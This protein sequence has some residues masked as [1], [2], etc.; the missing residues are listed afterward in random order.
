MVSSADYPQTPAK[1]LSAA[2][3]AVR[4]ALYTAL[5]AAVAGLERL[6]PTPLPWIRLGLA[7]G[8][9]LL[10]L[11]RHGFGEALIVN[12]QRTFLVA[13]IFGTWASPALVLSLGGA[14]GAMVAMGV[15][16]AVLGHIF[17]PIGVSAFGAFTH[18][19][20]QFWL[21]ALLLVR[22]GSLLIFAGP[23]LIAA[24]AS[25]IFTGWIVVLVLPRMGELEPD[26]DEQEQT[27]STEE[28]GNS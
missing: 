9:A 21:A 19:T 20:I 8:V 24:V 4:I 25:G 7:N 26:L 3:F 16:R 2:R 12:L 11:Y 15:M 17:G 10:V 28:S 13:L 14:V 23:S 18:M 27:S 6:V 22:H 5:G 1:R